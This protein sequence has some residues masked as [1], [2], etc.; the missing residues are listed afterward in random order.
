MPLRAELHRL[1]PVAPLNADSRVRTLSRALLDPVCIVDDRRRFLEVNDAGLRMLRAPIQRVVDCRM[2]DFT[3][4]ELWPMLE[5]LWREF[6]RVGMIQGPFQVLRADRTR[7]MIE[8]RAVRDFGPGQHVFAAR[9]VTESPAQGELARTATELGVAL[10]TPREREVLQLAANGGSTRQIAETL[11]L[12]PGTVKTHFEN[13]Y[14][15]LKVCD[16]AS[17]VAEGFRRGLVS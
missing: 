17:A 2:D 9:E 6:E 16:R 12:S 14:K 5:R 10:I 3:P 7:T 1:A 8:F 15:K 13:V 4:R 11:F